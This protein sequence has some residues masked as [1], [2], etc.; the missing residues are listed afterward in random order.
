MAAQLQLLQVLLVCW[1]WALPGESANSSL[2]SHCYCN[3]IVPQKDAPAV[4][5]VDKRVGQFATLHCCAQE[6]APDYPNATVSWTYNGKPFPW[7]RLDSQFGDEGCYPQEVG[8]RYVIPSDRGNYT[9]TYT[10]VGGVTVTRTITLVVH[11][12]SGKSPLIAAISSDT[13]VRMGDPV[14]LFCTAYTGG[15]LVSW[16]PSSVWWWAYQ[17]NGTMVPAELVPGITVQQSPQSKD[18]MYTTRLHITSM[19]AHMYG[20][21][22]CRAS[23]LHNYTLS[24]VTVLMGVPPTVARVQA[25]QTATMVVLVCVAVVVVVLVAAFRLRLTIALAL[26]SDAK[27]PGGDYINDVFIVHGETCTDW[28]VQELVHVLETVHLYTCY[29]PARDLHGGAALVDELPRQLVQSRCVVIVVTRCLMDCPWSLWCIEQ[30]VHATLTRG[31]GV[32]A[33]VLQNLDG[34]EQTPTSSRLVSRINLIKKI[35]HPSCKV[36]KKKNKNNASQ[37]QNNEIFPV[38]EANK[39]S[40]GDS[41]DV[42]NVDKGKL[43]FD[44]PSSLSNELKNSKVPVSSSQFLAPIIQMPERTSDNHLDKHATDVVRVCKKTKSDLYL[45]LP[46]AQ[47]DVCAKSL[48]L[49]HQRLKNMVS[50]TQGLSDLNEEYLHGGGIDVKPEICLRYQNCELQDAS[51]DSFPNGN[52]ETNSSKS[53]TKNASSENTSILQGR[54][55]STTCQSSKR[56]DCTSSLKFCSKL[57]LN[58]THLTIYNHSPSESQNDQLAENATNSVNPGSGCSFQMRDNNRNNIQVVPAS[59]GFSTGN[60]HSFSGNAGTYSY[61]IAPFKSAFQKRRSHEETT[62]PDTPCSGTPFILPERNEVADM[63][64]IRRREATV[65]GALWLC[66]ASFFTQTPQQRFWQRL[67][68]QLP[69]VPL[70]LTP[71]GPASP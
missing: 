54:A 68:L 4:M 51:S 55:A 10:L 35:W 58:A 26:R 41:Y 22:T 13:L 70:G 52:L 48:S 19:S 7:T 11:K 14:S 56:K 38:N 16:G 64:K 39:N 67:L 28:V 1:C 53:F 57:D 62:E 31:I 71:T 42:V 69:A 47:L 18:G 25:Y 40:S 32:V 20:V 17:A 49:Q 36:P 23:N 34:L 37:I 2:P 33:V 6:V 8:A 46:E 61:S 3:R 60:V 59:T 27:D 29:L 44:P 66:C 24:N 50:S 45:N 63:S 21:Y 5:R 30:A 15:H 43:Y 12:S 9:C 65:V